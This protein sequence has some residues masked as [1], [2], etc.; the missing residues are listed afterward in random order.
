V[1][2]TAP[3]ES[4]RQGLLINYFQKTLGI[5][6]GLYGFDLNKLASLVFEA[7]NT[8]GKKISTRTKNDVRRGLDS[9][10]CYICGAVVLEKTED[11]HSKIEYEHLWPSSYGGE[12][13]SDNLLPS[14]PACNRKKKDLLLWQDTHIHSFILSP[15]PSVEEWKRIE[16]SQKIAKH[17]SYIFDLACEKGLSLKEAAVE[18]GPLDLNSLYVTDDDDA[19]DF[20][21]FDLKAH[22]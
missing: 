16:R 1:K 7:V 20:F 21:N 5:A 11:V 17:R 12:S 14:C 8:S 18:I 19:V 4:Q 10:V 22:T 6:D 15:A 13:I 3:D 9:L 2:E